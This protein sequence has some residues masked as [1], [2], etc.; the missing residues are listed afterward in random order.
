[1][2]LAQTSEHRKA[3]HPWKIKIQD[4][5]IGRLGWS[6]ASNPLCSI[7]SSGCFTD[8]TVLTPG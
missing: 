5:Q 2:G 1:M 4:D 8:S 6:R 3:I 7:V